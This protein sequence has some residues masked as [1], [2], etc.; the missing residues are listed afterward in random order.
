MEA[1][2]VV[3][4]RRSLPKQRAF[5]F[6]IQA[7][8]LPGSSRIGSSLCVNGVCL[9]VVKKTGKNI[10]FNVVSETRKR[11]TLS[12]LKIGD[13]VNL[14]RPLKPS[15]RLD[16]HFVL[17]HVDAVGIVRRIVAR[18]NEK[19]FLVAFPG[20]LKPYVL[21]KGSIAVDGVSLTLGKVERAYF[22]VH[23]IPHTLKSTNFKN[24][25]E[26]TRVNLE[27]DVLAKL[28]ASQKS[29]VH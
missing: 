14:E 19:S 2:G 15:G 5:L 3:R 29:K 16:G 1:L 9:T 25:R 12:F 20:S 8:K 10:F 18:G 13:E 7:R 4:S 6:E 22:W 17:G 26:G 11:S 24:F 28:A 27:A 23:G 21:E